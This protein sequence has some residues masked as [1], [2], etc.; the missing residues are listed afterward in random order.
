MLPL[1][2]AALLGPAPTDEGVLYEDPPASTESVE[3]ETAEPIVVPD[4]VVEPERIVLPEP[5]VTQPHDVVEQPPFTPPKLALPPPP[6]PP[7]GSGR[8][9]GGSFAIALGLG[10]AS[11]VIVEAS[12]DNGN[13]QFAAATF[14]PL[15][16]T[17]I[18][19][20]TYLLVRGAKARANFN[21]WRAFTSSDARPT[22]D[23]LIVAG[24]IS[25]LIG[26]VTLVA[27]AVQA[28]DPSA[29]DR[30]LTPTLFAIGA[31]GVAVG[32]GA[33][34]WGLLRRGKYLSWR[35]STFLGALTPTFTPVLDPSG[36]F[37]LRG[38]S[39]GVVARL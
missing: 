11:A 27:A 38:A 9:V 34:T 5:T 14:V 2:L 29:F 33:L 21:D 1:L 32:V 22:G 36:A 28:R 25:S 30:P 6:P 3:P 13:P 7:T 39:F 17:G 12:R 35:Q 23:G 37:A 10:A 18:G 20:G 15:G 8:L 31:T 24:T 16:L 26:G 4:P 19:V